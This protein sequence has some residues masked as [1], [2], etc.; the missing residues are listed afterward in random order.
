[1]VGNRIV[2]LQ[3]LLRRKY[4]GGEVIVQAGEC[5]VRAIHWLGPLTLL[6]M[7]R[8]IDTLRRTAADAS[9][10]DPSQGEAFHDYLGG[11]LFAP[12]AS[13]H[14]FWKPA[15]KEDPCG[16]KSPKDRRLKIF[17]AI[18]ATEKWPPDQ[19]KLHRKRTFMVCATPETSFLTKSPR[20]C[21]ETNFVFQR[22]HFTLKG[23]SLIKR[24]LGGH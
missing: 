7:N 6:A 22:R 13:P 11:S 21:L 20:E 9:L 14:S 1:M 24:L 3:S 4:D 5:V 16:D 17:R 8:V 12:T 2:R 10:R 23:T 19:R 15:F 18:Y